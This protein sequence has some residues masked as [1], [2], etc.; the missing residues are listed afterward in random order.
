MCASNRIK[1][2]L[3][4]SFI[5]DIRNICNQRVTTISTVKKI[6]AADIVYCVVTV[7][8]VNLII[9]VTIFQIVFA[10]STVNDIIT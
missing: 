9:S 2:N 5:K 1:T 7:A 6:R 8:A 10:R 4:A 3:K